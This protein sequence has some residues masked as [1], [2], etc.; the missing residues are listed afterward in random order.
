[1]WK[2]LTQSVTGFA[3]VE[4]NLR[5]VAEWPWRKILADAGLVAAFILT[6]SFLMNR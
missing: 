6:S 3:P 1:M 5:P 4:L 2:H